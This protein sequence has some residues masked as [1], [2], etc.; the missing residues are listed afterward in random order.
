[1]WYVPDVAKIHGAVE[2][3]RRA[4]SSSNHASGIHGFAA[5]VFRSAQVRAHDDRA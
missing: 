2:R 1:M 3:I 4:Q 5:A